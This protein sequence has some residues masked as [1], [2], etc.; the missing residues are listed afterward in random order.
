[1]SLFT[2]L[3]LTIIFIE[4]SKIRTSYS[5]VFEFIELQIGL[6]VRFLFKHYFLFYHVHNKF[7]EG[8]FLQVTYFFEIDELFRQLRGHTLITSAFSI[9]DQ[10]STLVI[11]FTKK[12]LY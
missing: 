1:M 11:V 8:A 5:I 12:G 7:S 10:L 3:P 2:L 9:M 6:R 4:I